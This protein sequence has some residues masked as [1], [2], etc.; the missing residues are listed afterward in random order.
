MIRARTLALLILAASG[1]CASASSSPSGAG[2]SGP[3]SQVITQK[4]IDR[5]G[6]GGT[7]YDLISK[8]RPNFLSSRGQTSIYGGTSPVQGELAPTSGSG[9]GPRGE[10][11][12]N[13]Y[14]DGANYGQISSLRNI[15]AA[16]IGEIR[17]YS[18]PEAERKFGPGNSPGVIAITT[19]R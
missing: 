19:R 10:Y 11:Y 15:E 2:P 9:Q 7:A 16:L 12:A 1:G 14:V 6:A 13:V 17:F 18:G 5:Y 8:L 3:R 4:E